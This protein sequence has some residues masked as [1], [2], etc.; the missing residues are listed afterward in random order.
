VKRVLVLCL[1]AAGCCKKSSTPDAGMP[2]P[3]PDWLAG[4]VEREQRTPRDGGTLVV[5]LPLEPAGL[6]RLHDRFAE[7]TMVRIIVGPVYETLARARAGGLEP[8][9]AER[10][11][12]SG[13]HL[14]LTVTVK[15]GVRFHDGTALT[16]A[17]VKATLDVVLDQ[18]RPTASFRSALEGV[19]AVEAP[20][21]RTVVIRWARPSY[22]ATRTLLAA[23]PIMPAHA[24]VGDFDTLPIHRAPIGT[25]P[26][27]FERWEPGQSLSFVRAEPRRAHLER[28]IFRFLKDDQAALQ[29]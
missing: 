8:L 4:K 23:L 29:A 9:L 28:V 18:A 6:T 17:D 24:L 7:G 12:E 14:A 16:S 5:R 13:D 20:D 27:R 15:E 3:T 10:W 2:G 1:L 21:A 26:F 22:L 25:G 19:T 11:V